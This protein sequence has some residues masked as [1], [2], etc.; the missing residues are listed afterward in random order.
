MVESVI[1]VIF[2]IRFI[3]TPVCKFSDGNKFFW[4]LLY[5]YTYYFQDLAVLFILE[6]FAALLAIAIYTVIHTI[7]LSKERRS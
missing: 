6:V 3:H 2:K 4:Q 1:K 7:L 5:N